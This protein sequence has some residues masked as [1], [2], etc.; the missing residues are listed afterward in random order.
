MLERFI[1]VPDHLTYLSKKE[2]VGGDHPATLD[3]R[4]LTRLK[5]CSLGHITFYATHVVISLLY[6]NVGLETWFS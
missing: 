1:Y 4:N 6:L 3:L 5:A 2:E